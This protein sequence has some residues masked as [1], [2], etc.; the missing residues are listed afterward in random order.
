MHEYDTDLLKLEDDYDANCVIVVVV[1]QEF[2]L[3]E[4]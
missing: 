4:I 1:H 3:T 2:G